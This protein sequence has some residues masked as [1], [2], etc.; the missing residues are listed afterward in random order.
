MYVVYVRYIFLL[1]TQ[2]HSRLRNYTCIL[3]TADKLFSYAMSRY[4]M[5]Q[6]NFKAVLGKEVDKSCVLII[7][8]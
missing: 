4:S 6:F 2:K 7:T 5:V 1:E 8:D 3:R